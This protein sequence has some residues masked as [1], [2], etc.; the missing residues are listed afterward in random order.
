MRPRTVTCP[1]VLIE[2]AG[3]PF[4]DLQLSL[5]AEQGIT[6]VVYAV[7]H[8]GGQV[9]AFVEDGRR[10]GLSVRYSYET[11]LLLG[12]AGA[13]RQALDQ[14]MLDD[15]FFVL[16]GDSYLTISFAEV[17][18]SFSESGY[19]ALMTILENSDH[20]DV[21]N[22]VYEHGRILLYDK[23]R[24][25]NRS[26]MRFIDYGL[27]VLSSSVVMEMVP[28]ARPHDIAD[29]FHLLSLEGRLAGYPVSERF[30][31]IGSPDGLADLERFLASQQRRD[32]S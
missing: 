28:P 23:R 29:V 21:S 11:D 2:V 16:Y 20:W 31:E 32:G 13:I 18:K 30:Y 27:S 8:L 6:D 24:R 25:T 7:G 4:A 19:P 5:L 17:A 10:W 14:A 9:E 15:E 1:K 26:T 12:T 3:V 22:A